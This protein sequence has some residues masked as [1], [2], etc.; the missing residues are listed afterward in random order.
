MEFGISELTGLFSAGAIGIIWFDIRGIRKKVDDKFDA[1]SALH[2]ECEK[3]LPER[4]A[5]KE[6]IGRLHARIDHHAEDLNY[7]KGKLN[8]GAK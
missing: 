3:T 4:F 6:D 8:G 5:G 7:L 1:F 2:H